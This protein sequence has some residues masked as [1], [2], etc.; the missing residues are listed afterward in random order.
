M[1]F[2]VTSIN[3]LGIQNEETIIANSKIEAKK[4]AKSSSLS[5]QVLD[6]KWI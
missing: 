3:S 4:Y 1:R 6:V 2:T 5:S